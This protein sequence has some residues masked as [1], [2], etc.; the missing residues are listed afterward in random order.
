MTARSRSSRRVAFAVMAA[1]MAAVGPV[2]IAGAAPRQ[3]ASNVIQH[4]IIVL[5]SGHSFDNYFG[6]R[7]GVAGIPANACEPV[8]VRSSACVKPYHLKPGQ[9]RAGLTETARVTAAAINRGKMDGFVRAQSNSSIGSVAMG[10]FDRSDLPFYWSLADR[11]TLFDQFFSGFRGGALPNR[12]TAIAGQ[13]GGI[14]SN[15]PPAGGINVPTVFDQLDSSHLSWK[16]YVQG[17]DNRGSPAPGGVSTDPLLAMPR[18][19]HSPADANRI[20]SS[21]QYYTDLIQ[22]TLPAVSFVTGT[23][24]SE[25]APQ[26]PAVGEAFVESIINALMQSREWSHTA[27]LLTYDDSGGWYDNVLP[28]TVDGI[29]LGLRVPAILVS[30]YARPGYVDNQPEDTAAIPAFIDHVFNLPVLTPEA[31]AAGN[32]MT[33]IDTHQRPSPAVIAPS[34]APVAIRPHVLLIY[35]LYLG[36]L[37]VVGAL[38]TLAVWRRDWWHVITSSLRHAQEGRA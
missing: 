25:R 18:I 21:N 26:N 22:G 34:S 9:A 35:L 20:V 36:A 13:D 1:C 37:L 8:A 17:Y 31:A 16:F 11:F 14:T 27:L 38:I 2:G 24:G 12:I 3:P 30:P 5:Q 19:L 28:P 33:A 23:T 29:P 4:V 15:T 6:T 10:Y 32:L 7:P